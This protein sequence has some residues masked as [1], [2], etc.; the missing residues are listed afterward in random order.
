[1]RPGPWSGRASGTDPGGLC[2]CCGAAR[3][4]RHRT[5][6]AD[7]VRRPGRAAPGP[8]ARRPGLSL[9]PRCQPALR[10]GAA[11]GCG[12]ARSA[13]GPA[14]RAGGGPGGG[15]CRR[16]G[17]DRDHPPGAAGAG[18]SAGTGTAAPLAAAVTG[19]RAGAARRYRV[20]V[21][22]L[23]GV[24]LLLVAVT[25]LWGVGPAELVAHLQHLVGAGGDRSFA[26]RLRL[27]RVAMSVA[28]GVGFGLAGALFQV[29]LRNPLASPDIIGVTGGASL[30]GAWA[31]LFGGMTGMW[32]SLAAF[33]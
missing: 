19:L 24:V 20:V 26:V 16:T 28:V 14:G 3:R 1:R 21:A 18:V 33:V 9:D 17:D 11:A 13:G 29:V 12:R 22:T 32:V 30:A 2:R 4:H 15:R 8:D 27:P 25:L 31:I 10:P 7:R 5:G 23:L 6:R